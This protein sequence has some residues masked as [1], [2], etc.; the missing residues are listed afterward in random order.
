MS[1]PG[2]AQ[3]RPRF[4]PCPAPVWP[5]SGPGLAQVWLVG[6]V[7][8]VVV[9][10]DARTALLYAALHH[11]TPLDIIGFLHPGP[12]RLTVGLLGPFSS[13]VNRRS[14]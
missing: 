3:V 1:R 14:I 7:G 12:L 9:D 11:S 2:S 5:R 8:L 6:L 13:V 10:V 4:G